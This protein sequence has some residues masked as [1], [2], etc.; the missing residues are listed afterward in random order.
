MKEFGMK[1]FALTLAVSVACVSAVPSAF[2]ADPV[3]AADRNFIAMVSQG[4]MFE[5]EAGQVGATQGSTQDIR[6]Q[7]TTEA[8]DHTL[9]G[10]KLKDIASAA[11]V[12]FPDSLNAQFQ[13]ELDDLKAQS[14]RSFDELYLRDMKTIHAKDGAA[15]A[16][17]AKSGTN[18]SLKAFAAETHRIV[19]RHIGELD[20]VSP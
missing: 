17:E 7:G 4:G 1:R 6:D 9:V 8:N 2:A 16:K 11:G 20:A 19:L 14:G 18:P 3:S 12:S 5:V 15:F 10:A 13:K